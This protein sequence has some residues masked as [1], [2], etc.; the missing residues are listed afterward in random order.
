MYSF[1]VV[2][3]DSIFLCFFCKFFN[4]I[5]SEMWKSFRNM[6]F[7]DLYCATSASHQFFYFIRIEYNRSIDDSC[8][9][10][11]KFPMRLILMDDARVWWKFYDGGRSGRERIAG[12]RKRAF[13]QHA[14]HI[15]ECVRLSGHNGRSMRDADCDDDWLQMLGY[16]IHTYLRLSSIRRWMPPSNRFQL[17]ENANGGKKIYIGKRTKPRKKQ[18]QFEQKQLDSVAL[19]QNVVLASSRNRSSNTMKRQ[20]SS[21]LQRVVAPI[22]NYR[23][24]GRAF[25]VFIVS[26]QFYFF[27]HSFSHSLRIIRCN[28]FIVRCSPE[29]RARCEHIVAYTCESFLYFIRHQI[30]IPSDSLQ[31]CSHTTTTIVDSIGCRCS[32]ATNK[33]AFV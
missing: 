19:W 30:T 24:S 28:W 4:C 14:S 32:C 11:C 33:K 22:G 31:S 15:S 8:A 29:V 26:V 7:A 17:T 1:F 20:T 27:P 18:L 12:G 16:V 10:A 25:S 21:C 23:S 13:G 9:H 2:G 5:S 3:F 6:L